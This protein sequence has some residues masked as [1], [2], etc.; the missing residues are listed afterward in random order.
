MKINSIKLENYRNIRQMTADFDNINIIWGENAQ[1]KTNLLEGIYLFTGEKSFRGARDSEV[2]MLGQDYAKLEIDFS[3]GNRQ[4][5]ARLTIKNRTTATLNGIKKK[6]A[7]SLGEEIKAV[8]FSPTHLSMIKGGPEERRDFVDRALCQLGGNYNTL[9]R[10]Y[11][12]AVKQRNS[13][14]KKLDGDINVPAPVREYISIWNENVARLGAKIVYQRQRYL[15]AIAPYITD[16]YSGISGGSEE[17]GLRYFSKAEYTA[18]MTI[19]EIE[20][21]ILER[22]EQRLVADIVNHTTTVGPHRDDITVT[23]N[24]NDVRTYASQGQQR[25]CVL[26]LKLAEASLLNERTGSNPIVLL[27]DVMSELDEKRQDYILNHIRD[28]QIFVTCCDKET[29]LRLKQGKTFHISNGEII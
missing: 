15:E 12:K 1:G 25:S 21:I 13:L 10:D 23:I 6:S 16:I 19:P 9:L 27:D 26:A 24:G 22:M 14:I 8:I 20:K 29:I 7:S 3:A 11:A 18:D 5:N 28:W 17:I 2:I 4:Q